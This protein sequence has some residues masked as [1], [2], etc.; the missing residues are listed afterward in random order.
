MR[1]T[2]L[3]AEHG[4]ATVE[5]AL[6]LPVLLLVVFGIVQFGIAFNNSLTLADAV[7]AAARAAV[8]NGQDLG[9]ATTAAQQAA[10]SSAPG[11][12]QA[13]LAQGL[14]VT[15]SGTDLTVSGTYPYS[16]DV[17]GIVVA[18]GSLSSTTTEVI[19]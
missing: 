14:T 12:D 19:E 11:L 10:A 7:R 1:R 16:I 4:Q 18:S 2:T 13:E 6:V 15:E 8:V 9:T 3:K 5:F 17:L